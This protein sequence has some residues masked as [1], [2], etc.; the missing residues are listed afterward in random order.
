VSNRLGERALAALLV[1]PTAVAVIMLAIVQYRWSEE[2]RSATS[3]RLADSLQMSMMS[4]HLNLFRDLSDL[5]LRVRL[6]SDT[7]SGPELARTVRRF[8][9]QQAAAAYP[10]VVS[11]LNL[12]ANSELPGLRWDTTTHKFEPVE[13]APWLEHLRG[14]WSGAASPDSPATAASSRADDG[15]SLAYTSGDLRHWRFDP[16]LPGLLRPIATD[17]AVFDGI[18]RA[19][20]TTAA[21]LV[22]RLDIDVIRTRMLPELASRYF[23]GVDGLD[24]QVALVAGTDPRRVLYSSEASFG[25]QNP[26]DAD[27]RMN[28]FGRPVDSTRGSPLYVFHQPS[29]STAPP[30]AVSMAWFP[31]AGAAPPQDDWQLV[32]RHRRGGALGAFVAEI[33]RRDLII[34]FGLLLV[35]VISMAM[36][37]MISQR[38]QRLAKVQMNFVTAVSHD[39]RTPITI[40][41]SA[42]DNIA[43]GVVHE[44]QQVAQYGTVIGSQARRLSA[45][46][47]QVLLFAAVRD[48]S[49]RYVL[50]PIE[51]SEMIDTTLAASA[52]LIQAARVSVE[53]D[54]AANLPPV[55]GD[56]FGLSQ[57]LQNLITNALKYG[58]E[59]AWLGV[60]AVLAHNGNGPEVQ[61]SISDRGIGIA[62][63][64]LRHIFKPF[65]RSPSVAATPIRGTGLG[66]AV[67][68]GVAEAMHGHVSVTST[69]GEGSTFTLH[70]PCA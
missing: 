49:Q 42:A 69:P 19:G 43:L 20:D 11:E 53:R 27:G 17:R 68:K 2:V 3:V 57:C 14:E 10:D 34:S 67:A 26:I 25:E 15:G 58:G 70:L 46:V 16:N 18:S 6:D 39:L 36:W 33:H 31:L 62:A 21:W 4:W 55:M 22:I 63:A 35:L 38:A 50:R 40:I 28:L 8:H 48:S 65:Y 5:C 66:L 30:I 64:D 61:V 54:I 12:I 29:R 41:A 47:E 1:V 23:T 24:Y 56:P 32:V 44:R 37:M 59:R 60:R 13:A 7:L 51:V 52:E 9:E 45:L